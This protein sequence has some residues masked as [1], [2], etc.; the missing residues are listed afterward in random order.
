MSYRYSPRFSTLSIS[1][2]DFRGRTQNTVGTHLCE[3]TSAYD[4]VRDVQIVKRFLY[5][6]ETSE[7]AA[8][9][10]NVFHV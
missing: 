3:S 7:T 5:F 4:Y 1:I 9:S 2:M 8:T 10:Q 6:R